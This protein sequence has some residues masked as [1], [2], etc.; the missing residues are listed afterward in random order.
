MRQGD[1]GRTPPS[2]AKN[3]AQCVRLFV[4]GSQTHFNFI[5]DALRTN[6]QTDRQR[7]RGTD[8]QAGWSGR[9][10]GDGRAYQSQI[11]E[12]WVPQLL[13]APTVS[14]QFSPVAS[15]QLS[16]VCHVFAWFG[17]VRFFSPLCAFSADQTNFA[18]FG[19][20]RMQMSFL[21]P[22]YTIHH[23]SFDSTSRV[24]QSKSPKRTLPSLSPPL[25]FSPLSP[26]LSCFIL[27]PL[28]FAL[29]MCFQF[30]FLAKLAMGV[31][32]G[33]FWRSSRM[34]QVE[35]RA[36]IEVNF[37]GRRKQFNFLQSIGKT[38]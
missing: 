6:T 33:F 18:H 29:W 4:M 32:N 27:I 1:G 25:P 30:A 23:I 17:S 20:P 9:G 13:A 21:S 31:F 2:P 8:R 35:S 24:K 15:C 3:L 36:L 10:G 11:N 26:T 12:M 28:L 5:C 22:N 19:M 7:D 34:T 14:C 38:S 16:P 37:I